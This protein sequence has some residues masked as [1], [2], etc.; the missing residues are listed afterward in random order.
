[1]IIRTVAEAMKLYAV[2]KTGS[3]WAYDLETDGL[4]VRTGNITDIALYN[5]VTAYNIIHQEFLNGELV[6]VVPKNICQLIVSNLRGCRL[7]TWNGSFDARFTYHYFGVDLS[8]SIWEDGMLKAHTADEN[9]FTY[10]LKETA[11]R[12]FGASATAEKADM[13]A[14]IKANGGT[15]KE[16]YKADSAIR[17]AYALK[18]VRLTWELCEYFERIIVRDGLSSFFQQEV[19]Q[20]YRLVT[21]PM[22]LKGIPVDVPYLQSTQAELATVM[23][24]L[25]DD[26]QTAIAPLL[27]P[28]N[29]WFISSKY[30]FE[31]S[32]RF[33]Q[34]L[35]ELIAPPLWPKTD[36]GQY[37]FNAVDLKKAKT[38]S[39]TEIKK[40][41]TRPLLAENSQFEQIVTGQIKC[42]KE[43]V[44][45]TQLALLK[46]DGIKHTFNILSKDNLK[47]LMFGTSTTPSLLNEK[48]LSFTDKGSPQ[49]D[50]DFLQSVAGKYTWV[51]L[52]QRY[53]SLTKIKSTY[54]D[55]ILDSQEAGIWYPQFF[56]HRTTSGRYSG[57]AQ[58]LPRIKS[59]ED[60]SDPI[61]R[62]Y[63]NRI[64]NF[65]I[66]GDGHKL[67]DADYESLEVVVFADDAGDEKLLNIIRNREDFY[68]R[69][70]IEVY[71][72]TDEFSSDKGAPNFL[73]KHR[74]ELRQQAKAFALGIRY[75]MGA[76]KL[77][78]DLG[79]SQQAAENIVNSYFHQF[80]ALKIRMDELR[81]MAFEYGYV[82]SAGGRIRRLPEIPQLIEK[83][84]DSILD[85]LE[86]WKEYHDN[87]VTYMQAKADARILNNLLN[88][89]L[90]M[91]IQS[92]AATIVNAASI[93]MT[94]Q[95][96]MSGLSAYIC[97]SIHDE[98]CVRCPDDEVEAVSAIMRSTMENTTKLKVPLTAEPNVG[99]KYG[100]VK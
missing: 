78:K 36:S 20:L 61:V 28:F 95:F 3:V 39:K 81:N 25:E 37:S 10:G 100:E 92:Y 1:M 24:K 12:I 82:Q 58:Q 45:A 75:G 34:A 64:R 22:E 99:T 5:G 98:I 66:S 49:I 27:G 13:L 19:M 52:L 21:I 18:D 16:F 6:V 94:K 26:I 91:P 50:D 48:A 83:W 8:E 89:A 72:L 9:Q 67:V 71:G 97:L 31:L 47:R 17:A 90:N 14:S 11:T 86:L 4:A 60:I 70:A 88:N 69:V 55:S 32:A 76:F 15:P 62:E 79:I 84:G 40:N 38:H 59:E 2:I 29:N 35:G 68:S 63:T 74:P 77:G 80:P 87:G 53:N 54:V 41:S 42:P 46:A 73:K 43:L 51:P 23:T 93:A 65:F 57:N 33:K 85:S 7:R 56:Q 44:T 30:K 96:R